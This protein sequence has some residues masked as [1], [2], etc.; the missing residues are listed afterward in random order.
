M[1]MSA[2]MKVLV[3]GATGYVGSHI[4]RGMLRAGHDVLGTARSAAGSALVAELGARPIFADLGA[5]ETLDDALAEADAVVYAAQLLL[6]PEH[7]ALAGLADKLAGSG[8]TL[9]FTSGTGVVSQKTDGAWS[10]DSFAED[11]VF[12]PAKWIARRV[13]T[14]NLVRAACDRGMRAM[15]VRPPMIWGNGGCGLI[16]AFFDSASS[17]GRVCYLGSGLNLYSNVHVDDLAEVYALALLKGTPG[18]LYHCVAGEVAHRTLAERVAQQL[19][20]D[21]RSVGFDE[22]VEIWG[23]FM[24]LIIMSSSS[25]TRSPRARREL[26]WAPTQL[27]MLSEV[28]HPGYRPG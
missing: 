21:T 20:C 7:Q 10:E 8:K 13:D 27:D 15:V 11:D 18:A 17:T 2:Q 25:R 19:G 9:I 24:A 5:P 6:D 26:G 4:V 16:Q 3:I 23:K 22:A 1:G 14:E 12:V 28:S